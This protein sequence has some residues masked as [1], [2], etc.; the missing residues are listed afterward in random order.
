MNTKIDQTK[1]R[2][3]AIIAH[4]D[5]GKTTL[6]DAFLK[7]NNVFR[8]NQEEMNQ[9]AILDSGDLEREKGITIK[10]KNVAINYKDY[11]INIIDTPGHADF[12]GEVERTL[13][14]ADGCL[15]VVDAQEGPMPQTRFVLKKALELGLKPI[16]VIN[17]ID[18]SYA[19]PQK[20]LDKV[21][22]LFLE[23]AT[24]ESQLEFPVFYA[25]G[26]AGKAFAELPSGDLTK[27]ADLPGNIQP[28]LDAIVETV[29]APQGDPT[30]PLQLQVTSLD[31]DPHLGR[32]LIGKIKRGT[33]RTK[34]NVVVVHSPEPNAKQDKGQVKSLM[35]REGLAYKEVS[36]AAAGEIVAVSGIESTAIGGTLCI[37]SQIEALPVIKLSHPSVQ[38]KF[39]ASSS[40]FVGKDGKYVTAKQLQQRLDREQELNISLEITKT[41]G[42]AYLVAGRGE[43]QLAILIEELR[44]ESYEFQVRRPEVIM[45]EIDGV[46]SEP[47]EELLIEVPEEYQGE[48]ITAVSERKGELLNMETE[49]G[50]A[51]LSYKILTRNLL[52]LR[53]VLLT[54]TKGNLIMNNFVLEY[55]PYTEQPEIFRKGVLIASETGTAVA[56][57][58]NTIQERGDL[59]ITPGTEVYEG[60]IVG[61]NKYDQ[62]MEVNVCKEREKS[63]VRRNQAEITQVALKTPLRLSLE[64][65]LVFLAKDE[66][67]EVTPNHLR[68]RKQYLT[69]NERSWA[70]RDKLSEFAKQKMGIG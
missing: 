67:L 63:G 29:P 7:Q 62:D 65:A 45:R 33:I 1:I 16:V 48:V 2:N 22:D 17:K 3:V 15:L 10:A 66:I 30:Q 28:L 19:N 23:L 8:S 31:F 32:F 27:S 36:E 24:D 68:L 20:A 25:I 11:K 9:E 21:T 52:G 50:H 69:K 56:Y 39:E 47:L 37:A 40:P 61:V 49:N 38:I 58:M 14:M 64:F 5:H 26:R 51:R 57:A 46:L 41:D 18:K 70:T 44:R 60:M 4:V 55:V 13:N 42:G 12:G 54:A 43:L 35:V 53:T 34:D 6:V 59:F